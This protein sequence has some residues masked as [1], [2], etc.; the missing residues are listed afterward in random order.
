MGTLTQ[1]LIDRAGPADLAMHAMGTSSVPEQLGGVLVLDTHGRFDLAAARDLLAQ[2]VSTIERLCQRLRRA[3]PLCGYPVWVDD[4][5][6]DPIRHI[7]HVECPAPGDEA[8]LLDIAADVLARRLPED[9]PGWAA[10]FVTGLEHERAALIFVIDHV[11]V[12]GIGGVLALARLVD[13]GFGQPAAEF[14]RPA[15]SR[16]DLFLDAQRRRG[17]AVAQFA[18]KLR[19]R[20]PR[21]ERPSIAGFR[22]ARAQPCSLLQPT[23]SRRKL[24]V[25]RSDVGALRNAAH[26][27]GGT[28]N[29]AYLAAVT[30]ALH[31]LLRT[32]GESVP[33]IQAG[34]PI[35]A[36]VARARTT[37]DNRTVP[38]SVTLPGPSPI[39]E[40]MQ[41]ISATMRTEKNRVSSGSVPALV[42]LIFEFIARVGL[43]DW[44]A[45][46]QHQIHTVMSNVPGPPDRLR[47]AGFPIVDLVPLSVGGGGNVTVAFIALSYAG[48]MTSVIVADPATTPDLRVLAE[49]LQSEYDAIVA[50]RDT[51]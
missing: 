4:A 48:T 43:Y 17:R 12:D 26:A 44:Y 38:V 46:R 31:E 21:S 39:D 5:G 32:R 6:F 29:D 37:L 14:P 47:F 9:R 2:R 36:P 41:S 28:I 42:A 51:V 45:K 22:T 25:V 33:G 50:R 8:A 7:R 13:P 23:S 40:R 30:G 35:A 18:R 11:L 19:R 10:V 16:R 24:A 27:R 34:V 1:A 3:P 49:A 20:K 15:P